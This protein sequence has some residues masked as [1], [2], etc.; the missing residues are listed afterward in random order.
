MRSL[1]R[2]VTLLE[3]LIHNR[4]FRCALRH[5]GLAHVRKSHAVTAR[6][7]PCL[8]IGPRSAIVQRFC[9]SRSIESRPPR[10]SVC[11]FLANTGTVDALRP[12]EERLSEAVVERV[13]FEL[14]SGGG[15]EVID[16][17]SN[18]VASDSLTVNIPE[19]GVAFSLRRFG[20]CVFNAFLLHSVGELVRAARLCARAIVVLTLFWPNSLLS[21]RSKAQLSTCLEEVR[22]YREKVR[23]YIERKLRSTPR[24]PAAELHDL[25]DTDTGATE[26]RFVYVDDAAEHALA[27]LEFELVEVI[28][29]IS[30]LR[31]TASRSKHREVRP[32]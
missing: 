11:I 18:I 15:L 26:A 1:S 31:L 32:F 23:P 29:A 2:F 5:C 13:R 24:R 10:N 21:E 28:Y 4:P 6:S 9:L 27:A 16:V 22:L 30:R 20:C 25:V 8:H 7:L 17:S 14:G 3:R 12:C 19:F